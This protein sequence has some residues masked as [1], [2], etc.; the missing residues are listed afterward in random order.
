MGAAF[1]TAP[2][3]ESKSAAS[4]WALELGWAEIQRIGREAVEAYLRPTVEI[5]SEDEVL[6][7]WANNEIPDPF[8][9][10]CRLP[11]YVG[12]R[13]VK[14][15]LP[16]VGREFPKLLEG[17]DWGALND[18][19]SGIPTRVLNEVRRLRGK[20]IG[21]LASEAMASRA[22]ALIEIFNK[23]VLV[24]PRLVDEQAFDD[25]LRR[26]LMLTMM[27]R[28]HHTYRP[29]RQ[30]TPTSE[31][32]V[33][34]M[35][36]EALMQ[37]LLPEVANILGTEKTHM[38]GCFEDDFRRRASNLG[39]QYAS[40]AAW[41][42]NLPKVPAEG[43]GDAENRLHVY[44]GRH[45]GSEIHDCGYGNPFVI[46]QNPDSYRAFYTD[47]AS[48]KGGGTWPRAPACLA[49]YLKHRQLIQDMHD[50]F[51]TCRELD[52]NGNWTR[53]NVIE[54]YW[55]VTEAEH[56]EDMRGYVDGLLGK[57][58]GCYC[59]PEAC[60]GHVLRDVFCRSVLEEMTTW[61]LRE[62]LRQVLHERSEFQSKR[63]KRSKEGQDA[64][65]WSEGSSSTAALQ[66]WL[67]TLKAKY[68]I[69]GTYEQT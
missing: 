34:S 4:D 40:K 36:H 62:K 33:E 43:N 35:S 67:L 5:I 31:C 23:L 46:G 50:I 20:R 65:S 2:A 6:S 59:H 39:G 10:H 22:S 48:A 45:A 21:Y 3:E 29:P 28:Y 57:R 47:T 56:S 58:L 1:S 15:H 44:I 61:E 42:S 14:V 37:H 13:A 16:L 49:L 19:P 52:D 30:L 69:V 41:A 51:R 9:V 24:P 7:K 27:E 12:S 26:M 54:L 11:V 68:E 64:K 66:G 60:H 25:K 18:A 38:K 8:M 55:K 53:D 63:G 32:D 17:E